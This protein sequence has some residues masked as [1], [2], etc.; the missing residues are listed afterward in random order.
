MLITSIR[1]IVYCDKVSAPVLSPTT[2]T[3]SK[4]LAMMGGVW[5]SRPANLDS[6][7]GLCLRILEIF[8]GPS[9]AMRYAA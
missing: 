9:M 2:S 8:N 1:E 3:P 5:S 7:I 6:G 4:V